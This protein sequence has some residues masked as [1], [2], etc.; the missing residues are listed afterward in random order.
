MNW[1][2]KSSGRDCKGCC[3]STFVIDTLYGD[4]GGSLQIERVFAC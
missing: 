4:R 3:D 1:Q 2:E